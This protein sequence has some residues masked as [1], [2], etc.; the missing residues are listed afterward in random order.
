[1]TKKALIL[2]CT[3]QDGG[4]LAKS[5]LD[6]GYHVVGTSRSGTPNQETLKSLG[7]NRDLD[8]KSTNIC[9]FRAML[10]LIS[11]EAPDEIYNL[12][13]QSS[14]NLSFA[15]PTETFESI[16]SGTINLLEVSRFA[17]YTGRIFFAGSS[18][19]FGD[20]L[21]PATLES[22]RNPQSPYAIAKDAALNAVRLYR[23]AYGIKC[24]TG[25]LFNHESEFRGPQYVTQKI[26]YGALRCKNDPRHKLKLGNLEV[27]RD[28]GW[29]EEYVE[30][31]QAL[32]TAE[33][34]ED[35]VI[36]TGRM[37]SLHYFVENVFLSL[38][39]NWQDHV[40][41]D[42]KLSRPADIAISV[43]DPEPMAL[44]TRWRAQYD[45]DDIIEKLLK[46]STRNAG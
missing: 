39:L 23:S 46:R 12:A 11:L 18:E 31:M 41:Q 24:I 17:N 21:T 33:S 8:I 3:G 34:L 5:L 20:T 30:A 40:V 28:W 6:K 45:V 27:S 19:I 32:M 44:H 9:D 13:A 10:E 4:L 15:Q 43:G 22:P 38:G 1:M 2:G 14:V 16:V 35:H 25:V 42:K 26:I 36:C 7:I 29:A 37:T